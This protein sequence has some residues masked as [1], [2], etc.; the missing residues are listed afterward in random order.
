[1]IKE[2]P[3]SQNLY[4]SGKKIF[5]SRLKRILGFRPR[6][7]PLYELA[8]I[9]KSA[10]LKLP[11]GSTVNNERLE[12][13]GDAI[14]DAVISDYLFKTYAQED[15][16]FLTKI[17]AKIVNRENLNT[18]AEKVGID[19]LLISKVTHNHLGRNLFGNALEALIGAI[20]LDR[21]YLQTKKYLIRRVIHHLLN[22]D[23]LIETEIDFKSQIIEWAQKN[24][25]EIQFASTEEFDPGDKTIHFSARLLIDDQAA[26]S[27]NGLT[28]KEAEQNAAE[29]A[30]RKIK[31]PEENRD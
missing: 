2:H 10:S 29:D 31:D 14:L 22:L 6:N 3:G 8:F 17:R 21:G 4:P 20:Y 15:E 11:D 12:F 16:G 13:L 9:H 5:Y 7:R 19:K 23:E 18:L 27:G 30:L 26:G 25:K 28:K 24:R 1:M